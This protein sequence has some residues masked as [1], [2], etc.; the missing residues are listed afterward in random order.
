M[1]W[2]E[3]LAVS[4]CLNNGHVLKG[5]V[6]IKTALPSQRILALI[7]P[8]RFIARISLRLSEL[9]RPS[10]IIQGNF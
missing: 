2:R 5:G 4:I 9:T 8:A 1:V 3:E 6:V 10:L 7:P